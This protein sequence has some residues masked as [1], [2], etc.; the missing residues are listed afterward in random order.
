MRDGGALDRLAALRDPARLVPGTAREGF[1]PIMSAAQWPLGRVVACVL[2]AAGPAAAQQTAPPASPPTP[3]PQQTSAT[4][5]DWIVRCESRPGPPVQKACEM[6]QF[7][8]LKGQAGVLTQIGIGKPVKGQPVRV[9][10][11][12]PTSVWLPTGVRLQTSDKDEGI[13][14]A[15]KSCVATACF[16][17]SDVKDDVIRKWRAASEPGKLV[18]KD[19]NQRDIA[20]PVSFKGFVT[21]YDALLKE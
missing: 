21:A 14:A 19:A 3:S 17:L 9:A 11:Q 7:T 1:V 18:F 15:F 10:I 2:F 5:D 16:G 13:L 20:L 6:V 4:Y 8:Q 12:V